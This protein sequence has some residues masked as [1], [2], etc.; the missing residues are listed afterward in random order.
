VPLAQ[1]ALITGQGSHYPEREA[2]RS[3]P[4]CVQGCQV[5]NGNCPMEG[6]IALV[7]QIEQPQGGNG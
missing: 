7:H 5:W 4:L 2:P 1:Q 3:E 6:A